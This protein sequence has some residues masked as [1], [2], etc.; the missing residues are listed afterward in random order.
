MAEESALTT[1]SL[2]VTQGNMAAFS[3][4]ASGTTLS[5]QWRFNGGGIAGAT[6]TS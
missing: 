5:Y 1:A 4:T 6:G 2:T 3:V